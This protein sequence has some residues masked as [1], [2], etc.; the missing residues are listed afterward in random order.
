MPV[1]A[2]TPVEARWDDRA[3]ASA[4]TVLRADDKEQRVFLRI[5]WRGAGGRLRL[6]LG[7][8]AGIFR[9]LNLEVRSV[10]ANPGVAGAGQGT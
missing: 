10:N 3:A 4:S 1:V 5:P 9:I 7:A 8:T 2:D 6:R